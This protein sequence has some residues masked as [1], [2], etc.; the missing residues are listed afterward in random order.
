HRREQ[1]RCS[2]P[3]VDAH[4][5]CLDIEGGVGCLGP[6]GSMLTT[7][8]QEFSIFPVRREEKRQTTGWMPNC[9]GFAYLPLVFLF[10]C[11]CA[12]W[13]GRNTSTKNN[14]YAGRS[15]GE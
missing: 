1:I 13:F 7:F 14:V 10:V 12:R 8:I 3:T 11:V 15:V 4:A 9:P 5:Q 2:Q 6:R